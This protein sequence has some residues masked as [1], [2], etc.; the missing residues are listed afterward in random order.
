MTNRVLHDQFDPSFGDITTRKLMIKR[1]LHA[2]NLSPYRHYIEDPQMASFVE[3]TLKHNRKKAS[4]PEVLKTETSR[5]S[6]SPNL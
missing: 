2:S 6:G 3:Q 5:D 4:Q 1:V